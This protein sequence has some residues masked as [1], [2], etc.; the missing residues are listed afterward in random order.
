MGLSRGAAALNYGNVRF[1][2]RNVRF[3]YRNVNR[4]V[5]K[6]ARKYVIVNIKIKD[7]I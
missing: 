2:Y 6:R 5:S 7:R 3:H 4:A 1:D